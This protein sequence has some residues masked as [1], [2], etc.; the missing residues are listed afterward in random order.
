MVHKGVHK[1][2]QK[3]SQKGSLSRDGVPKLTPAE[4]E[5]LLMITK[6]F[7]TVKQVAIRRKTSTRAVYNIR[8]QLIEKGI[9]N[10]VNQ[11]VSHQDIRVHKKGGVFNSCE[12][13][14]RLHGEQFH[15]KII[16]CDDRYRQLVSKG[17]KI[18]TLDDQTIVCN[19]NSIEIYSTLSYF[20]KST[21]ECDSK[22]L[23]YWTHFFV[24]LEQTVKC[25]LMKRDHM[26]ISR[27]KAE[28][29]ETN[30]E[31]A[32]TALRENDKVRVVGADGK[33][34]LLIDNSFNFNECETVHP[35]DSKQ[36]MQDT[37]QP[38]FNDLRENDYIPLSEVSK[39]MAQMSKQIY[40]ISCAVQ[41]N[42]HSINS[43]IQIIKPVQRDDTHP[44]P[45]EK[46]KYFG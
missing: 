35:R 25:I 36:D 41:A 21:N 40:E 4:R 20:G 34:W 29:A 2:S 1:P 37:V 16:S 9:L 13:P 39:Y 43:I 28:Y 6:D 7:M 46:P 44:T 15:I 3:G 27:V 19:R 31:I 11:A 23:S 5:V 33:V 14:I 18:I 17:S 26:N 8:K 10:I 12:H 45:K 38:F 24:R 32:K 30:N 22:A 42:A